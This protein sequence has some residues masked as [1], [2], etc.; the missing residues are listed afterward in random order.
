MRFFVVCLSFLLF[1]SCIE[2][3]DFTVIL[4]QS[5]KKKLRFDRFEIAA[6]NKTTN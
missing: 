5:I 1:Q 3:G 6:S 2:R 4:V